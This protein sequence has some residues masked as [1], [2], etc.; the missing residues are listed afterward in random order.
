MN[1]GIAFSTVTACNKAL[2]S[3]PH[4][5]LVNNTMHQAL[6]TSDKEIK[7]GATVSWQEDFVMP[8]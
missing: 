2:A 5:C 6:G 8:A 4:T 7:D 1:L 3:L